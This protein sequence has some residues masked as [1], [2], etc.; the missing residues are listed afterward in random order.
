MLQKSKQHRQ[1]Y[2]LYVQL[3]MLLLRYGCVHAG[4][5]PSTV[6]LVVEGKELHRLQSW[7]SESYLCS[8]RLPA[9]AAPQT[10]TVECRAEGDHADASLVIYLIS[11]LPLP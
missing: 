2:Q 5:G 9:S 6:S 7:L 8:L 10:V 4:D 1:S 3:Q 11:L